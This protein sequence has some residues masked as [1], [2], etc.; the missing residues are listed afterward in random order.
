VPQMAAS[1]EAAYQAANEAIVREA[2]TIDVPGERAAVIVWEGEPRPGSDA[3]QAFRVL[4]ARAG[5]SERVV[6]TL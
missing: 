3:T 5:F 4:A 6:P 2:E 1:D